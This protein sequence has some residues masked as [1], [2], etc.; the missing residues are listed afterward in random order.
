MRSEWVVWT[1]HW[2]A[3]LSETPFHMRALDRQIPPGLLATTSQRPPH[4]E[5]DSRL[6]VFRLEFRVPRGACVSFPP[7]IKF[8]WALLNYDLNWIIGCSRSAC[9]LCSLCE[10]CAPLRWKWLTPCFVAV[11]LFSQ[12]PTLA[13]RRHVSQ[14]SLPT[15][16]I[17]GT[18]SDSVSETPQLSTRNG[19]FWQFSKPDSISILKVFQLNNCHQINWPIGI[20]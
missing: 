18:F 17:L 16:C 15:Q 12:S 19:L 10:W 11:L 4:C 20:V 7:E 2:A 9:G 6:S 1:V 5:A 8:M 13:L 14:T 3:D